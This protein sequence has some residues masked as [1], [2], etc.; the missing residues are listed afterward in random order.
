MLG[1]ALATSAPKIKKKTFWF[2]FFFSQCCS[3]FFSEK[4]LVNQKEDLQNNFCFSLSQQTKFGKSIFT[5]FWAMLCQLVQPESSIGHFRQR[6]LSGGSVC[7][8]LKSRLPVR[9]SNLKII[10]T[11]SL[12]SLRF[13]RPTLVNL[14][15]TAFGACSA[16][17]YT[18]NQI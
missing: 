11:T 4:L 12:E 1:H 14:Y 18:Q 8:F 13:N 15:L 17:H 10:F 3:L 2:F 16:N 5:R 7:F 9:K 6:S